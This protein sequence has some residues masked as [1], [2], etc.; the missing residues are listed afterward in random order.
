M[1]DQ[2]GPEHD[3]ATSRANLGK[4]PISFRITNLEVLRQGMIIKERV[5]EPL[6]EDSFTHSDI[7]LSRREK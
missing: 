5:S 1:C 2:H 4:L 3:H 7:F 6:R